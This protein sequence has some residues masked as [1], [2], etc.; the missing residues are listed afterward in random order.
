MLR[1][2]RTASARLMRMKLAGAIGLLLVGAGGLALTM[3]TLGV[4]SAGALGPLAAS[5][6]QACD[7]TLS[8]DQSIQSA[9]ADADSGA[10]ICLESGEWEESVAISKPLTLRGLGDE[11][12]TIRGTEES[13]PDGFTSVVLI[14]GEN[15][16]ITLQNLELLS[17][18]PGNLNGVQVAGSTLTQSA[19]LS[20]QDTRI[21]KTEVGMRV[22]GPNVTATVRN[23]VIEDNEGFGIVAD[24]AESLTVI[25]SMIR[26]N[27]G[28]GI[29]LKRGVQATVRGSTIRG[30]KPLTGGGTMLTA[31][32]SIGI[33]VGTDSQLRLVDS[34]VANNG[35]S[36]VSGQFPVMASFA[37]TGVNVGQFASGPTSQASAQAEIVSSQI[38]ANRVGLVL[39]E[40]SDLHMEGTTVNDSLS[41]GVA[42][43]AAPCLLT[44]RAASIVPS[45]ISGNVTFAGDNVVR[46]NN[47]SGTLDGKGNPGNHPFTD[48]PDGQVC[49]PMG[50]PSE[51]EENEDSAQAVPAECTVALAPEESIQAAIDEASSGDTI[52][53][54]SGEYRGVALRKSITLRG[55]GDE[56]VTIQGRATQG[57]SGDEGFSVAVLMQQAELDVELRNLELVQADFGIFMANNDSLSL[58]VDNVRVAQ[59]NVVGITVDGQ[60]VTAQ[61]R[62]SIIE[63]NGGGLNG[64]GIQARG[65]LNLTV[66][67]TRIVNNEAPVGF[68]VE[69]G[70]TAVVRDTTIRGNAFSGTGVGINIGEG[71]LRLI[72]S[73]VRNNG[74]MSE[75]RGDLVR[76][77]GLNI[78]VIG[79]TVLNLAPSPASAEIRGSEI[80]GNRRGIMLGPTAE[81]SLQGNRVRQNV[82]W[83]LATLASPC[84]EQPPGDF[85][86]FNGDMEFAGGNT[87]EGNNTSGALDGKGNPGEHPFTDLPDGQVCLPQD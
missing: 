64:V 61:I 57:E 43:A 36:E 49:L 54:K 86:T 18:Q 77:A 10:T 39:G 50:E 5:Q 28:I 84:V 66:T 48:L 21:A 26:E 9:I 16:D 69:R 79:W 37:N 56:R 82:G 30:T 17:A 78:G 23:A 13:T 80:A 2:T 6:P 65:D 4:G 25:D 76:N 38:Q 67:D 59:T 55:L 47:T 71:H 70:A 12:V 1:S 35:A 81:A 29:D 42:G 20:V 19:S 14:R 51:S 72:N 24:R 75:G 62:N 8:P 41:W 52:C 31:K 44:D 53:L 83:G 73:V 46:N 63:A 11:R 33:N 40:T 68:S 22:N 15:V 34:V 32:T 7:V 60:N 87:I 45:R 3:P 58:T 85:T 74:G 27:V